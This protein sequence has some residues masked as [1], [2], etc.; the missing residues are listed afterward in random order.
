MK[1]EALGLAGCSVVLLDGYTDD[2]GSFTRLWSAA[3]FAGAGFDA[4]TAEISISSN[5]QFGTLRGLHYQSDPHGEAK[6]V[7][8]TRG[9]IFDVAVDLRQS[10]PTFGK[11]CGA[12]LAPGDR[13][14]CLPV[15][16]AHGFV[17]LEDN[18]ELLYAVSV[19]YRPE[20][21]R[22]VRWDDPDIAIDWP[23]APRVMS[24]WDRSLPLL[25]EVDDL[26]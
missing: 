5:R 2:R 26:F 4:L 24:D 18:S 22:G 23:V 10:S 25:G 9:R 11:W 3:E 1:F 17:T 14:V 8:C 21:Q 20:S 7:F 16:I 19:T 12:E 13:G 15:G 6:I